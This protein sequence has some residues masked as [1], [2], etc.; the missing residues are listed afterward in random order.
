MKVIFI[1]LTLVLRMSGKAKGS[2]ASSSLETALKDL[3]EVM[4]MESDVEISLIRESMREE[5]AFSKRKDC[6]SNCRESR[7]QA[8]EKSAENL[9]KLEKAMEALKSIINQ[10]KVSRYDEFND[11]DTGKSKKAQCISK[12]EELTKPRSKHRA[13]NPILEETTLEKSKLQLADKSNCSK[14]LSFK[15]I[16]R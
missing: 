11:T 7:K 16:F 5:A 10:L 9:E 8:I 12:C 4:K 15:I 14:Y 3:R 6:K 1:A 2:S 13:G